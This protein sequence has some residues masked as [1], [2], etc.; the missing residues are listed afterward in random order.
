V[1]RA[2]RLSWIGPPRRLRR[3]GTLARPASA[4]SDAAGRSGAR[5]RRLRVAMGRERAAIAIAIVS[6]KDPTHFPTSA[7]GHFHGMVT[8]AKVGDLNLDRTLWRM[9]KANEPRQ[10]AKTGSGP[11][12]GGR[13]NAST[14]S[15]T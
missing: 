10:A 7:G 6:T 13:S 5:S 3:S 4:A 15:W 12:R 14:R 8:K 11:G 1:T 9:R 2:W